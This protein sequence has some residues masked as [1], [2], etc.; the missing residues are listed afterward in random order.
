MK[1]I[2]VENCIACPYIEDHCYHQWLCNHPS[3]EGMVVGDYGIPGTCP[4][5]EE[6]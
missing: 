4:L 5:E 3:C 6:K 2:K 1:I